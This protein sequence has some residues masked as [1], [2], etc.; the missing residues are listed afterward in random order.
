MKFQTASLLVAGLAIGCGGGS[1]RSN[2]TALGS[3]TQPP[4]TVNTS[5]ITIAA[6][7]EALP[8]EPSDTISGGVDLQRVNV[9]KVDA[10]YDFTTPAGEPFA[11]N[12]IAR[13]RGNTGTVSISLAHLSAGGVT[14]TGDVS[15]VAEAGL[16]PEAP[17]AT[18]QG[19]WLEVQGDGFT[20]LGIRGQ[21]SADQV[22]AV[23]VQTNRGIETAVVRVRLGARSAINTE[24]Q[25]QQPSPFVKT[26]ETLYSSDS[27]KF[28][29][30]TVAISGDRVSVVA[31]EGDANDPHGTNRYEMRLQYDLNTKAVTGGGSAETSAD[32]GSWRDHEIAALFN[33]LAL[34]HSGAGDVSIKLSFDRGA[35]FAQSLSLASGV[36]GF[37]PRLVQ[38]AMAT[39]YTL[40][41]TFWRTARDMKSEMVLVEGSPSSVDANGSPTAFAFNAPQVVF[42]EQADVTPLIMGLQYSS[43][44]DLVIGY[45]YSKRDTASM[46]MFRSVTQYRCATRLFG[47]TTWTDT[48]VEE[49]IV[50]SM[51]PS[52]ALT[53]SGNSLSISYA[54]EVVDGIRLRF[55]NDAGQTFSA[56]VEIGDASAHQPSIFVRNQNGQTRVD[57]LYLQSANMGTEL[58]VRHWDHYDAVD[59]GQDFVLVESSTQP[60]PN[61]PGAFRVTG[62]SWLGYDA[63]LRGD[64]IVIAYDEQ[65][66]DA[67]MMCGGFPAPAVLASAAPSAGFSPA[68][69]PPLAPGMTQTLPAPNPAHM[70]QL[71]LLC[72]D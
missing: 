36:A 37:R 53:G 8:Q 41:V 59:P 16:V 42:T 31:Y 1:S 18:N 61:T 15:S 19:E 45:G 65:T 12:V 11:F 2:T 62:V 27:W 32:S 63:T 26:R 68:A 71:K 30:P 14:P 72:I 29:L 13:E 67:H 23:R 7:L 28:G 17:G 3:T 58:R 34:V 47:S 69:P 24:T 64:D 40:A 9:S 10:V 5:T 50:E 44:G 48:L 4:A 57:L 25:T 43:G 49:A 20:R 55:S 22:L 35:S 60:L 70:H 38:I 33:V 6:G 46:P 39:D 51:D 56:P 52:I 54:Y 66:H 21:I